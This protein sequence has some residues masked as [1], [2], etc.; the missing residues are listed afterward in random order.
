ML[1]L[2]WFR[3]NGVNR[4]KKIDDLLADISFFNG[5]CYACRNCDSDIM[6]PANFSDIISKALKAFGKNFNKTRV[7]FIVSNA[8]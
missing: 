3:Y 1:M 4:Y 5:N 7:S 6:C 2:V 8:L